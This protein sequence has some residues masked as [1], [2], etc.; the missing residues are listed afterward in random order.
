MPQTPYRW[1]AAETGATPGKVPKTAIL[2]YNS[3]S[4][5]T[6]AASFLVVVC[7]PWGSVGQ[8]DGKLVLMLRVTSEIPSTIVTNGE[9]AEACRA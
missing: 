1:R 4:N 7:A 9:R 3:R 2:L 5:R 8:R 6:D